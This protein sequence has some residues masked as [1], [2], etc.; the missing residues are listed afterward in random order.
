MIAS[1]NKN[2]QEERCSICLDEGT[3][4]DT[5]APCGYKHALFHS[6]CL[7][8]LREVQGDKFRCPH[9]NI[10]ISSDEERGRWLDEIGALENLSSILK[11]W[12]LIENDS[13]TQ[14]PKFV[15]VQHGMQRG[16]KEKRVLRCVVASFISNLKAIVDPAGGVRVLTSNQKNDSASQKTFICRNRSNTV[17]YSITLRRLALIESMGRI[18][19]DGY[20]LS[21]QKRKLKKMPNNH[22]H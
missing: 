13:W 8:K 17:E 18:S 7:E 11:S 5:V 12:L 19:C 3:A 4:A 2:S 22:Y 1:V 15:I 20:L 21:G 6:V 10:P 16:E 9:C 14:K